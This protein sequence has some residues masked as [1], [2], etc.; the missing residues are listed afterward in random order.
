MLKIKSIHI[1]NFKGIEDLKIDFTYQG[2]DTILDNIVF[3]GINGSGKS[4]ILEAIY[5][6]LLV[7]SLFLS[8]YKLKKKSEIKQILSENKNVD[9][10]EFIQTRENIENILERYINFNEEWIYNNK[11]KFII[12][13]NYSFHGHILKG[14]IEYIKNQGI[15]LKDNSL[16]NII[17][18]N[19][20]YLS[21]YRLLNP[22][23]VRTID[24]QILD[25]IPI[26]SY[27][28]DKLHKQSLSTLSLQFDN[29]YKHTKQFLIN[30]INDKLSSGLSDENQKILNKIHQAFK[31]FFPT[32]VFHERLS[33][34]EQYYKLAIENEDGSIVDI[35]QLSSGEREIMAFFTYLCR[36]YTDDTSIIIIDEPELHL[37]AKWQAIILPSLRELFPK[38]QIFMASHSQ[39]IH[40]GLSKSEIFKLSK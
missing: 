6:F 1:Q 38:A 27:F 14:N 25:N 13:V 12:D 24:W 10:S 30:L 39:E 35:D 34:Q 32:K 28:L 33:K 9:F 37:H 40:K 7:N 23:L 11:N 36:Q 19:F 31:L 29:N 20:I 3:Y 5:L 8:D 22:E 18:E 21:S 16:E 4:T 26:S 15:N 17:K 2:N